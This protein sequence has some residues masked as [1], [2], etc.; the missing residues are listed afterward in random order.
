MQATITARSG[1]S[2]PPESFR[3][4]GHRW[5]D[6]ACDAEDDTYT[7]AGHPWQIE[8]TPYPTLEFLAYVRTLHPAAKLIYGHCDGNADR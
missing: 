8:D 5:F 4:G 6:C 3:P 7:A 1:C 2:C